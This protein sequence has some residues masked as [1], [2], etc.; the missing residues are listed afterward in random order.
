MELTKG[1]NPSQVRWDVYYLK[2]TGCLWWKKYSYSVAIANYYT[3]KIIY[4]AVK[5]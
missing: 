4:M 3:S 5:Y 1:A 2:V